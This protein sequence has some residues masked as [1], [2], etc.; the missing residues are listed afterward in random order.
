MMHILARYYGFRVCQRSGDGVGLVTDEGEDGVLWPK[1]T[2][3][4]KKLQEKALED[5]KEKTMEG[6]RGGRSG[7][8]HRMG[9]GE[10]SQPK[11]ACQ[12]VVV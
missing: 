5:T 7:P 3:Q 2:R 8:S 6:L 12:R 1:M 9:V 4:G 11:L 10:A